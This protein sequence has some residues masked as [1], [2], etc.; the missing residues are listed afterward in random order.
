MY[1]FICIATGEVR[2]NNKRSLKTHC[3]ARCKVTYTELVI[4]LPRGVLGQ[5]P[6]GE[7]VTSTIFELGGETGD[8][9]SQKQD[10]YCL[11]ELRVFTSS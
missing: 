4:R 7:E 5:H 11:Y 8:T 2:S 1:V 9:T 10:G 6:P 3:N